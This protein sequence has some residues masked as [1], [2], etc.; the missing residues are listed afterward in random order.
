MRDSGRGPVKQ[1]LEALGFQVDDVPE[2]PAQKRPDLYALK[3]GTSMFVE[4]KT[5][6]EDTKLRARMESVG[7]GITKSIHVLLDKH[8]SLSSNVEEANTQLEAASSANDLRLLWF[9]AD[10]GL[11]VQNAPEQIRATLLGTRIV[12]AKRNGATGFR[13]CVYAGYADFYRYRAIDGAIIEVDGALTLIPNQ[14]S[15]R[16]DAFACSPIYRMIAPEILDVR[17][18]DRNDTLYAIESE[19]VDRNDDAA[20]LAFLREKYPADEFLSFEPYYAATTVT[21]IDARRGN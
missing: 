20:L 12:S 4:V 6:T 3:D 8:A 16:Q 15:P 13:P 14:F 2:D 9:R 17:Q 5:R 18:C 10:N 11:F 7:V 1:R 21:T 19:A